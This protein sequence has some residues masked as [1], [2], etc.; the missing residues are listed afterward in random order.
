MT[1]LSN[2]LMAG[3]FVGV[4]WNH[5]R[6]TTPATLCALFPRCHYVWRTCVVVSSLIAWARAGAWVW[7]RWGGGG[8]SLAVGHACSVPSG[9][10]AVVTN[11]FWSLL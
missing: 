2:K 11:K 1:D 5:H 9:A 3:A 8:F 4:L 10:A 7:V 6:K